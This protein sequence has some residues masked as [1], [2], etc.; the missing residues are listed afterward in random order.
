MENESDENTIV[1]ELE[2]SGITDETVL[3]KS[4]SFADSLYD[5]E[6]NKSINKE[7]R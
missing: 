3:I 4:S 2:S 6:L 7:P 1:E 5:C